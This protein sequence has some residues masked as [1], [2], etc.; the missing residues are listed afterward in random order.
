MIAFSKFQ[1]M[2]VLNTSRDTLDNS[3]LPAFFTNVIEGTSRGGG[4]NSHRLGYGMCHLFRVLFW[5]ENKFLGL[6][7]SL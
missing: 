4:G 3:N 5:L 1:T 6:F 7:Y 2:T